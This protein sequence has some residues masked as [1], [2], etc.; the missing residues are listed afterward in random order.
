[1]KKMYISYKITYADDLT[2]KNVNKLLR[3]FEIESLKDVDFI[4]KTISARSRV[5]NIA[6]I[7]KS[8]RLIINN[9]ILS[10]KLNQ[11]LIISLDDNVLRDNGLNHKIFSA[12]VE[13]IEKFG[14]IDV[15][16]GKAKH[17]TEIK[18]N[19]SFKDFIIGEIFKLAESDV[20]GYYQ[21]IVT[22]VRFLNNPNETTNA[23]RIAYAVNTDYYYQLI[24]INKSE[25]ALNYW[26]SIE[27]KVTV[28][29]K[30]K[31]KV[32]KTSVTDVKF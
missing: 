3:R 2:K 16:K 9:L 8:F 11:P 24:F 21:A 25:K 6:I 19:E 29:S 20:D 12:V 23:I 15:Y 4:K 14:L 17:R 27:D 28:G 32:D 22:D 18:A 13:Q 31:I 10:I 30:A 5:K 26:R 7:R 1:M